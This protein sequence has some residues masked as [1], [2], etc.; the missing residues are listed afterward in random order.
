L[1]HAQYISDGAY[2]GSTSG[3][4]TQIVNKADSTIS[5]SSSNPAATSGQAVT[6]TATVQGASPSTLNPTTGQVTFFVDGNQLG[7]PVNVDGTGHATSGSVNLSDGTH[8]ITAVYSGSSS[9]NAPGGPATLTQT[10]GKATTTTLSV[11]PSQPFYGQT[12]TYLATVA[13]TNGGP[14]PTG[15]V[16]FIIDG[17]GANAVSV[18]VDSNGQ[19]ILPVDGLSAGNHTVQA[20]YGGDSTYASSSATKTKKIAKAHTAVKLTESAS[21]VTTK[22]TVTFTAK[23]KNTSSPITPTGSVKFFVDGVLAAVVQ[24]DANGLA[25]AD[26]GPFALGT[27]TIKAVYV[28]TSNFAAG[29]PASKS[30]T[31][32]R[33]G[34]RS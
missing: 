28:P 5:L 22:D 24:L 17:D 15:T 27:R 19:A 26:L 13:A 6:F 2:T 10:V 25:Q 33:A 20:V 23:V 16:K 1:I 14:M 32:I 7:Q 4:T 11:T 3:N 12:V 21:T 31:V 34:G 18:N 9:F 29:L 30:L 8:T